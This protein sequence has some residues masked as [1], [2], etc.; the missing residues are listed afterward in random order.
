ML[1]FEAILCDLESPEYWLNKGRLIFEQFL[2]REVGRDHDL[3]MLQV[4]VASFGLSC[5]GI[6]VCPYFEVVS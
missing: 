1:I 3:L 5:A 4:K 6:F 2:R